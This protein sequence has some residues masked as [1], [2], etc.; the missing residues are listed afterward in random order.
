[1]EE[2]LG[3]VRKASQ[4]AEGKA[5]FTVEVADSESDLADSVKRKLR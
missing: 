2:F 5:G 1:M 4:E 3:E